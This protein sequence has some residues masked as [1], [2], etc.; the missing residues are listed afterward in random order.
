MGWRKR[1][2]HLSPK[3]E[4]GMFC[5]QIETEQATGL[6]PRGRS[7]PHLETKPSTQSQ[8]GL[9]SLYAAKSEHKFTRDSN[10]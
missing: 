2:Q 1:M 4:K 5:H 10:L 7:D 9:L 8:I 6:T 3:T